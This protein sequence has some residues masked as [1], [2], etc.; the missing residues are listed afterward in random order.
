MTTNSSPAMIKILFLG[1]TLL[2]GLQSSYAFFPQAAFWQI[3]KNMLKFSTG[4]QTVLKGNCSGIT[5]VGVYAPDNTLKTVSSPLTVNLTVPGSVTLYADA[6]C[7]DLLGSTIT[8]PAGSS[9]ANFYFIATTTG[10]KAFSADATNYNQA[11]QTQTANTNNFIWT[12]TNGDG[13]WTTAGNWSGGVVPGAGNSALFDGSC[14]NCNVTIPSSVSVAGIRM[15]SDYTGT[16]TQAAGASFTVGSSGMT[17]VN[18][19]FT[20]GDSTITCTGRI[21]LIGGNFTST[22]GSFKVKPSV[23]LRMGNAISFN[24]NNGLFE[25]EPGS[26]LNGTATINFYN[27]NFLGNGSSGY[28][29]VSDTLNILGSARFLNFGYA[30]SLVGTGVLNVSKDLELQGSSWRINP[31]IKMVGTGTIIGGSGA[32]ILNL[33]I[34]TSGTITFANIGTIDIRGDFTYTSGTVVATGS[35]VRFVG[36]TQAITPGSIQ[37]YNVASV[38]QD[39]GY[40]Y[41]NIS[42]TMSVV[43]LTLDNNSYGATLNNGTINVSGDVNLIGG[44]YQGGS[45]LVRMVGTG[46]IT[47]S[48]SG[49]GLPNLEIATSGTVTFATTGSVD[50]FGNFTYTSGSVVTTNSQVKIR[51]GGVTVNSGAMAFNHLNFEQSAT[52]ATTI[53]GTVYVNGN[54]SFISLSYWPSCNGGTFEVK[55]NLSSQSWSGGTSAII[56]KGT[57]VQTITRNASG[58]FPGTNLTVDSATSTLTLIS[59]V[60]LNSTQGLNVISG[61]VNMAGLSLST[62]SLSLNGNTLTKNSGVLTVNG[63]VAGTGALYGGTVAP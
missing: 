23:N 38:G 43:N 25:F 7:V 34:A 18:G 33:E 53:V 19:T 29:T 44:Y 21:A 62:K 41:L 61:S 36:N 59:N 49:S 10:T 31:A 45:A 1:F 47:G 40:I 58:Y 50:I 2:L 8:I 26:A 28:I 35:T 56:L 63:V 4:A 12:G 24:H 60:A 5:T 30:F 13:L 15:S 57:G 17:Q 51:S 22:S 52:V 39:S 32:S 16:I 55:G 48:G 27:I 54:L 11:N 3:K 20:G 9:S 42:G 46:T 37:F 6:D 14:T